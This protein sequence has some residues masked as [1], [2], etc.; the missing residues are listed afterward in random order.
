MSLIRARQQMAPSHLSCRNGKKHNARQ[1]ITVE[2]SRGAAKTENKASPLFFLLSFT[3]LFKKCNRN[4]LQKAGMCS[5][6]A[7]AE[8]LRELN[9]HRPRPAAPLSLLPRISQR[10]VERSLKHK[11]CSDLT[12]DAAVP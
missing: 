6:G 2:R 5:K 10:A 1:I 9:I 11:D 12:D 3:S 7:E 4:E 8:S